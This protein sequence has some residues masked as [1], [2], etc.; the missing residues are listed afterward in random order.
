MTLALALAALITFTIALIGMCRGAADG[1][2]PTRQDPTCPDPTAYYAA[3]A[4]RRT[5]R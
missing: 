5:Y 3:R 1:D 2:Q 4:A